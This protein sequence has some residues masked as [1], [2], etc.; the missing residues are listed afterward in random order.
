M[1]NLGGIIEKA[2]IEGIANFEKYAAQ[3]N[4]NMG[5]YMIS[6][7]TKTLHSRKVNDWG[8][9]EDTDMYIGLDKNGW[10]KYTHDIQYLAGPAKIK[11][12]Y[13]S[14][15]SDQDVEA[16]LTSET[17]TDDEYLD[18]MNIARKIKKS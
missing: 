6:F 4:D 15:L 12:N 14:N 9:D 17:C 5:N 11:D 8:R 13:I 18:F 7:L 16:Y 2:R 1:A 10:I 3:T